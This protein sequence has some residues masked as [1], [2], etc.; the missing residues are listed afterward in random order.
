MVPNNFLIEPQ[1]ILGAKSYFNSSDT[2]QPTKQAIKGIP[3]PN[4][5]VTSN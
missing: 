3:I 5:D 4:M 2:Q 1:S